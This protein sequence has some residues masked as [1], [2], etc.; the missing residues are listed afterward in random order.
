MRE[1]SFKIPATSANLGLGFDSMGVALDLFLKITARPAD[2]WRF[3]FGSEALESLPNNE[4]NMVIQ[5]AKYTAQA[6]NQTMPT[7]E[8]D[9]D[10]EI[11]LAHG[12][13]SSSSALVAGIELA[14]R[15]LELNLSNEEKLLLGTR[16][17]GHPDNIGPSITGG[18]FIGFYEEELIYYTTQ[19]DGV[20]LIVSVPTYEIKTEE[21]RAALPTVYDRQVAVSQNARN[22]VM[23]LAMLNQD[24]ETMGKLMMQ[25]KYHQ[26][27]R[28]P[29]IKEYD[30]VKDISLR[31]GAYA[32]VISGAGPTML[33]L[34]P[35][36]KV[37]S[38]LSELQAIE[39]CDHKNVQIY[40]K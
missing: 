16:I 6:H 3:N 29:L 38:I 15:F 9:M 21:A 40:Y 36:D 35:E 28:G 4:E 39:S 18:V 24:Y 31:N 14:D 25:D 30:A 22:N 7:L 11:P 27:Y 8:I 34:C 23:I 33:T 17:E 1:V 20:S 26:P 2:E 19:L 37:D 10:S 13:G 32:T 12:L 5:M